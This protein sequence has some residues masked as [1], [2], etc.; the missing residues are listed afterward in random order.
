ASF[1]PYS[2]LIKSTKPVSEMLARRAL[3]TL[4]QMRW[5]R[6]KAGDGKVTGTKPTAS[7]L[8]REKFETTSNRHD[9]AA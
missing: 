6:K 5:V 8:R 1:S 2:S 9:D 3:S 7:L 4:R